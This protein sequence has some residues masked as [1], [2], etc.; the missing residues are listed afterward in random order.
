MGRLGRTVMKT[1]QGTTLLFAAALTLATL[2]TA[3]GAFAHCDSLDGP[4]LLDAKAALEKGDVTPI[5]KWIPVHDEEEIKAAFAKTSALRVKGEDVREMADL[6]FFETLVRIHRAGEGFAY[7]GLK[8]S[9]KDAGPA[10]NGA[11]GALES[12][13]DHALTGMIVEDVKVGIN[14]RF[15]R[16]KALK[17]KAA[18]S[19]E[20]G[21]EYVAAYVDYVHHVEGIHVAATKTA[22]HGGADAH[23]EGGAE[24]PKAGG[25]GH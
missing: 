13:C 21:R 7:T 17:A 20:A 1:L 14:E 8:G 18:D 24:K 23:A 19:V 22:G 15:E 5:L 12:G 2:I 25:C 6:Y 16:T 11:D 4:V 3:A 10:V 9:V